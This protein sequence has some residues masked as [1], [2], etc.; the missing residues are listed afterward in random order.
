MLEQQTNRASNKRRDK[1][2]EMKEKERVEK[3]VRFIYFDS[4]WINYQSIL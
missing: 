1:T 3:L 2:R 4:L